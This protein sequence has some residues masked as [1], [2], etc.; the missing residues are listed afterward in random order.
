MVHAQEISIQTE[1]NQYLVEHNKKIFATAE[2][3]VFEVQGLPGG[4]L[5]ISV[6]I[7]ENKFSVFVRL[8]DKKLYQEG[9]ITLDKK[10]EIIA[11]TKIPDPTAAKELKFALTFGLA[12]GQIGLNVQGNFAELFPKDPVDI[13]LVG[14]A[15]RV[16]PCVKEHAGTDHYRPCIMAFVYAER[17]LFC[18]LFKETP[19]QA[20]RSFDCPKCDYPLYKYAHY[21]NACKSCFDASKLKCTNCWSSNWSNG[22]ICSQCGFCYY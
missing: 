17:P 2:S 22:K 12:E 13:M 11:M 14:A 15:A 5:D 7:V 20:E 9:V 21:C 16:Y 4:H 1:H 8:G 18:F 3:T 19:E 6:K 10:T